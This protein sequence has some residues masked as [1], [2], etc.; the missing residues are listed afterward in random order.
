MSSEPE[1]DSVIEETNLNEISYIVKTNADSDALQHLLSQLID[2]EDAEVVPFSNDNLVDAFVPL[3]DANKDSEPDNPIPNQG[4]KEEKKIGQTI[5]VDVEHLDSIMNLVGELVIDQ[6]RIAQVGNLLRD[7]YSTDETIDDLERISNHF[8]RIIGE[9]QESVMKTRMLPVER[10]FN[11]FPRMV[12]DLARTLNKEVNLLLEGKETE[13]DRTVIEE[14]SDP[15]IH[16]IRNAIDH[17][18][19]EVEVRKKTGKI[20]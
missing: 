18:I 11:R 6:T 1:L 12:R 13:L 7:R 3:T 8:S 15:L 9:L 14:I 17:G 16:L 2:V 19:E 4:R 10:L 20:P 5:R